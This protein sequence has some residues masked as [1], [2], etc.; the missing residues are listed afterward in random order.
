MR[1]IS[2]AFFNALNAARETGIRPRQFAYF[3]VKE[4]ETGSPVNVGLWNGDEDINITVINPFSGLSEARTYYGAQNLTISPIV[5]V[6]DA[7]TQTVTV[8][9]SQISPITQQIL[10]GYDMRLGKVEIH[11]MLM[12]PSSDQPV[13]PPEVVF[14]GEINKSPLT[15]PSIGEDGSIAVEIVSDAISMLSK[16]NPAKSSDSFIKRR[17]PGD[18]FSKYA[19]TVSTWNIPWG[20]KTKQNSAGQLNSGYTGMYLIADIARKNAGG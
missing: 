14:I 12:G 1:S 17:N 10:R 11:E 4:R 16:T 18:N 6:T 20:I 7:T 9:A 15:T 5:R 13:S 3:T 2:T 8:S 19:S